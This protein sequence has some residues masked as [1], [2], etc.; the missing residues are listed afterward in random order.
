MSVIWDKAVVRVQPGKGRSGKRWLPSHTA[1]LLPRR[2][3]HPACSLSGSESQI[4][5][6]QERWLLQAWGEH[7]EAVTVPP[8]LG[9]SGTS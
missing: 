6:G 8:V 9:L 7:P 5:L 3:G 4:K 1:M 2:A